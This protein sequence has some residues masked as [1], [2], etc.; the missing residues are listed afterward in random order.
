MMND[1]ITQG[2]LAQILG[3][4]RV[5]KLQRNG[6]LKP[7]RRTAHSI[8]FYLADVRACWRRLEAGERLPPDKT[9]TARVRLSE[10][11]NGRSYQK[12]GRPQRPGIDAIELDF[13]AFK[14]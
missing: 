12:K 7:T 4:A 2:R 11:R 3:A 13:S 6:W 5:L 8:L 14:L 10:Q 9:E 1:L